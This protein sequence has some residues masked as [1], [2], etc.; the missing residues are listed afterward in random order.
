MVKLE[1]SGSQSQKFRL[2]TD[3]GSW[4]I[5]G[6]YL[7]D[8]L[9][10]KAA[11]GAGLATN[12]GV[13][14]VSF[15]IVDPVPQYSGCRMEGVY[16]HARSDSGNFFDV[17][18]K[19][20]TWYEWKRAADPA[21]LL[22]VCGAAWVAAS[23]DPCPAALEK[24]RQQ[25]ADTAG[26]RHC[27]GKR[28]FRLLQPERPPTL[29][30]PSGAYAGRLTVSAQHASGT[31][32]CTVTGGGGEGGSAA[33]RRE[34]PPLR[35]G[36]GTWGVKCIASSPFKGDSEPASA[37]YSVDTRAPP[38]AIVP[39]RGSAVER[40]EVA[41][42]PAQRDAVIRFT[43]DGSEPTEQS[44]VYSA[45]IAVEA[46]G[47]VI[48]ALETLPGFDVS[49]IASSQPYTIRAKEPV[50]WPCKPPIHCVFQWFVGGK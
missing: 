13:S 12:D 14:V 48:R 45:P 3:V 40:L 44:A 33:Q 28:A 27:F 25:C 49:A 7:D 16:D 47:T 31:V 32:Q 43:V 18:S 42:A 4:G 26:I 38:P 1:K 6:P 23:A 29:E 34:A 8:S 46:D 5:A 50:G 11:I 17:H 15:E 35:L 37:E 9:I 10:C 24:Y 21:R 20:W 22:R 19:S 39:D 30:P 2:R 36:N 41:L